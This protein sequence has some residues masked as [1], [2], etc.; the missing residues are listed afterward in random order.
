MSGRFLC[1]LSARDPVRVRGSA[2]LRPG[3]VCSVR[4]L[5]KSRVHG[6]RF[7]SVTALKGVLLLFEDT[8]VQYEVHNV[9]T[10]QGR[11]LRVSA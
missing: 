2:C 3:P 8:C 10:S 6:V 5:F 9:P 1:V 7:Q 4:D 11:G